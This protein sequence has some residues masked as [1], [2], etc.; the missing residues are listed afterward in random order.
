MH[1]QT[2]SSRAKGDDLSNFDR[3]FRDANSLFVM[4]Q[5]KDGTYQ[6][7]VK[8]TIT[9]IRLKKCSIC[10]DRLALWK[11]KGRSLTWRVCNMCLSPEEIDIIRDTYYTLQ[12]ETNNLVN[13]E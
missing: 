9:P 5:R 8:T 13:K 10:M 11:F 6:D 2:S 1:M 4:R 7:K 12:Y 3:P